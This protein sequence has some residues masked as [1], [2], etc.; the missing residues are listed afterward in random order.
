MRPAAPCV[1]LVVTYLRNRLFSHLAIAGEALLRDALDLFPH[2]TVERRG[3][4][5]MNTEAVLFAPNSPT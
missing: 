2:L 3:A 1:W 5:G 4:R